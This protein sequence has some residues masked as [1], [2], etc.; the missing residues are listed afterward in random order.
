MSE[1][2]ALKGL[3]VLSPDVRSDTCKRQTVVGLSH[4]LW[5]TSFSPG[6]F[7]RQSHVAVSE[8]PL[9]SVTFAERPERGCFLWKLPWGPPCATT[10]IEVLSFRSQPVP[11]LQWLCAASPLMRSPLPASAN[12]ALVP[13]AA[14]HSAACSVSLRIARWAV[15]S[16]EGDCKAQGQRIT[17]WPGIAPSPSTPLPR[18]YGPAEDGKQMLQ[19]TP[20]P[21]GHSSTTRRSQMSTSR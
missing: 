8:T 21:A 16:H 3:W 13:R 10:L 9:P 2:P 7:F 1:L 12:P 11:R 6:M 19:Q 15:T 4:Q 17:G 18:E 5:G 20:A 14:L